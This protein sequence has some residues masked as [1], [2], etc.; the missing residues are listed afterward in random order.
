MKME[1]DISLF[2]AIEKM[3]SHQGRLV[4]KDV[5]IARVYEVKVIDLRTKIKN[6]RSHFP[7]DFMIE[8]NEGK[9]AL[10]EP[11]I[12]MLG[13]LLKTDRAKRAHI[14]FIK[15]FIHLLHENG[16]SVYNSIKTSNNKL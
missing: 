10:T 16:M 15:Y 14:Q 11:G 5:D 12:L 2:L 3:Y 7:S 4:V 6:N 8:L 9:Y 13:G 1:D